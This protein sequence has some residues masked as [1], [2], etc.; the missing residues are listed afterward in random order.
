MKPL[1][2][3]GWHTGNDKP[4]EHSAK[5]PQKS[6]NDAFPR[7]ACGVQRPQ[8]ASRVGT[9]R[10]PRKAAFREPTSPCYPVEPWR[11]RH[12]SR[13]RFGKRP[14]SRR[15]GRQQRRSRRPAVV[16]GRGG[17]QQRRSR[18]PAAVPGLGW[19]R[20]VRTLVLPG[21]SGRYRNRPHPPS[22]RL[23][24]SRRWPRTMQQQRQ[25]VHYSQVYRGRM[26]YRR[27]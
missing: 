5:S 16:P 21:S 15:G 13:V 11:H 1:R 19:W 4:A 17:R 3:A 6:G 10:L 14:D 12:R 26:A 27:A 23:D 25:E 7:M 24:L 2:G 20:R 18:R 9:S 22:G 8:R